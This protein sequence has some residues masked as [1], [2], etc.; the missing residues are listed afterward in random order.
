MFQNIAVPKVFMR[1]WNLSGLPNAKVDE[2][3]VHK[4][5]GDVESFKALATQR[6]TPLT[7][8][9]NVAHDMD[10]ISGKYGRITIALD[11]DKTTCFKA[12]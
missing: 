8:F 7:I 1:G 4:I 5:E 3:H 2:L 9:V 6:S 11:N 12:D 10:G